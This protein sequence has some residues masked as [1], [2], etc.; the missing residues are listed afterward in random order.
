MTG[1]VLSPRLSFLYNLT[2][3]L[4]FRGGFA[5][6]FRAPQIFDEDL[7]IETS[8]SRQVLHQN[9]PDLKQESSN[10]VTASFDYTKNFGRWQVQLLAEGFY[11]RLLNPFANQYGEP[12]ENG[13]VVYT[14]VNAENG[15]TVKGMNF[16]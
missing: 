10:S 4:Q 13:V 5:R 8:G 1:N 9:D 6:G 14:R 15:A 11:T 7:H 16:D 3:D 12:D 2:H